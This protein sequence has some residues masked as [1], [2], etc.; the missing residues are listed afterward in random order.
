MGRSVVIVVGSVV[1]V[2]ESH[3][4]LSVPAACTDV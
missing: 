4:G 3:C 1:L 2:A